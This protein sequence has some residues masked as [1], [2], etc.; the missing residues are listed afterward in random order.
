MKKHF[1]EQYDYTENEKKDIFSN[2]LFVFDTNVLLNLYRYTIS[3]RDQMFDVMRTYKDRIWMPYQVGWEFFNNRKSVL[4]DIAKFPKDLKESFTS[5]KDKF[6]SHLKGVKHPYISIDDIEKLYSELSSSFSQKIDEWAKKDPDYIKKDIIWNTLTELF[7]NNVGDDFDESELKKIYAEGKIR[8]ENKIPPGYCDL[9]DKKQALE[10][11][12][13][14]DLIVWKQ[15]IAI[16]KSKGKDI[17]FVTDDVKEDWYA[18]SHQGETK[19][20]RV[21]LIKEFTLNTNGKRVLLYNQNTFLHY[22][23][24][25]LGTKVDNKTK[26]EVKA[27][28]LSES[29][30]QH[31]LLDLI[32]SLKYNED[33]NYLNYLKTSYSPLKI[34]T[35]DTIKDFIT[36]F[37]VNELKEE[38]IPRLLTLQNQNNV[39]GIEDAN[40]MNIMNSCLVA[41]ERLSLYNSYRDF[42]EYL[43]NN[44]LYLTKGDKQK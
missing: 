36:K 12:L 37:Y 19:R 14:G 9:K 4:E 30:K 42:Y 5:Q 13:Y 33:N 38:Q 15:S 43:S 22:I 41:P 27:V 44:K 17:V 20:A 8:Y 18:S 31:Y 40:Y 16:A 32:S 34:T 29:S 39:L 10:R 2:C 21:E 23:E 1:F 7:D 35:Q 3:T 6:I 11:R 28:S 24:V 26:E 25:Y